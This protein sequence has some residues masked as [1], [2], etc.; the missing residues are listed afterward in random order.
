MQELI[1]V[2]Y[3]DEYEGRDT[4]KVEIH[5][6]DS[7]WP[8]EGLSCPFCSLPPNSQP[9]PAQ[10]LLRAGASAAVARDRL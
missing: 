4:K 9:R 7:Q 2:T 6:G 5:D 10:V 8:E 1:E 3:H